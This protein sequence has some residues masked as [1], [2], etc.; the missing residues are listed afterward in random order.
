LITF[1]DSFRV[2]NLRY[3][4]R[5]SFGVQRKLRWAKQGFRVSEFQ[6]SVPETSNSKLQT[7]NFKLQTP[8]SVLL[9]ISPKKGIENPVIIVRFV[10][11]SYPM[12]RIFNKIPYTILYICLLIPGVKSS[13]QDLN[14]PEKALD[15]IRKYEVIL[16]KTGAEIPTSD[17]VRIMKY[18]SEASRQ[19]RINSDSS[20]SYILKALDIAL[21]VKS[22]KLISLTIQDLGDFYMSR[23]M[24][25][26]AM[27]CYLK[28]FT[29]EEIRKDDLRIADLNDRLGTV[30]YYMEVFDKS[31]DY[32]KKALGIYQSLNDTSGIAGVLCNIGNLHSSREFCEKRTADEK[33]SDYNAAIDFLERSANLYS[34]THNRQGIAK[35][36]QH[37]AAVYN[38]MNKPEMALGYVQKSLDYYKE[39]NDPEGIAGTLYTIGKTYYRDKDYKRSIE[40][41]KESEK[42]AL[43]GNLTGGIQYL[44]EALA[45]PYYDIGDF[46]NAYNT[47]IKYMTIRD[48]V[49]NSEK[50]KQIIE[51][52]TK[53]QSEIKQNEIMRLT[54]EKKRKNSLIYSLAALTALLALTIIYVFR[55]VKKNKII[56]DQ[57][58]QIKEDKIRELEK[59]R[60]YLAA[61][62]VMEGE[63]AERSRLAGDLHNGLGG[64]LSG[65][66]INLSA[67]KENSVI[68][69]ENISAFNHAISLLDTSITELR[70]IA[71]NLMPETL[72]HYGLKT[73]IEDF[74]NQVAPAGPPEIGFQFF[75]EN[76]RYTKELELTIYRIIQE[77]VNN[78][79]KHAVATKINVEVISEP[80]R[81]FARVTDNGKGFEVSEENTERKGKGLQNLNDRVVALNGTFDVWSKPGQGTEISA[82]IQI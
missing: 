49:Y 58:I 6:G 25:Q 75:G 21:R 1:V 32:H 27:S 9:Q 54:A 70:R 40:S 41:F 63:E 72:N 79:L 73:A 31:L 13:A 77:L 80:K 51:L 2:S 68:T 18:L 8:N 35:V 62:S 11:Y 34:V 46:K 12:R 4:L 81:L 16:N 56:S 60:M 65:I 47:Y 3:H 44:Y 37:I 33:L 61:R 71:H 29:I 66:K 14:T 59:E 26:E 20:C 57:N 38:K 15:V 30:Y 36:N 23:E 76:I 39:I 43:E 17:S 42:I 19:E 48:S 82:E 67:M 64:L 78:A 22:L 5:L 45:M 28:C 52:E 74:C 53:Y 69:H 24:Y 55:L 7:P 50:S 10:L